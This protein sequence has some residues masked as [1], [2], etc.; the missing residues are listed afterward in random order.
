MGTDIE[1]RLSKAG[2][3]MLGE[4]NRNEELIIDIL[5]TENTRY[6][7]A[8][9]FIIYKYDLNTDSILSRTTKKKLFEKI[10]AITKK[11][12]EESGIQK[13]I[14]EY[15]ECGDFNYEEFKQEFALQRANE[16]KPQLAIDKQ[17]IFSEMNLQMSLSRLFTKKEKEIIKNVLDDKP[18]SKTEYQYY[19]RKTKKKLTSII[20]LQEFA[21]AIYQMSPRCGKK[22]S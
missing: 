8:I 11:I 6:L 1:A 20:N 17:K 14:P 21:R 7:K 22:Q 4:H 2:F 13:R 15:E 5:K 18:V 10:L 12:F 3:R 16:E 19:S 9:P